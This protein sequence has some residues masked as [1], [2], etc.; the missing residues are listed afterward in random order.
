MRGLPRKGPEGLGETGWY[1]LQGVHR[2]SF[3][4]KGDGENVGITQEREE[5]RSLGHLLQKRIGKRKRKL[6]ERCEGQI[7]PL[8]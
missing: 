5:R 1:S 3:Y 4:R 2:C 7:D 8:P 6:Q